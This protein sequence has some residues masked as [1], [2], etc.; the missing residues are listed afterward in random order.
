MATPTNASD[1]NAVEE[2]ADVE[3]NVDE[4][5]TPVCVCVSVPNANNDVKDATPDVPDEA[6]I[7][8]TPGAQQVLEAEPTAPPLK[9]RMCFVQMQPLE[10][11]TLLGDSNEVLLECVKN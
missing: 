10:A 4:E 8:D 11:A 2:F 5:N 3:M 1:I 9:W 7:G 6:R